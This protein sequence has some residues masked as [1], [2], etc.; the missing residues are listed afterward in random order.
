MKRA[1]LASSNA[2]VILDVKAMMPLVSYKLMATTDNGMEALRFAHRFE[3]DLIIMGWDLRGLNSSEV[4][5]NLIGQHL[6]PIIVILVQEEQHVLAEVIEAGAHQIILYPLRALDMAA[7]IQIA[8]H[9]FKSE[10]ENHRK[11]QRLEEDIKTRKLIFQ[12][13]LSLIHLRSFSEEAAYAALRNHA[14]ST[15]R[16]MRAVA[17]DV[18]KGSW[19]P[20]PDIPEEKEL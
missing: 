12:A 10:T 19:M 7:A 4:L 18:I 2:Q 9:R 16:S 3:P 15:R 1:I 20:E 8:E 11:I 13:M 5:Q 17:Q 14:M 6:C